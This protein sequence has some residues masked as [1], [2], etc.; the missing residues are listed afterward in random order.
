MVVVK[1]VAGR[2][3]RTIID[4]RALVCGCFQHAR[5]EGG[6]G[7]VLTRNGL[8]VSRLGGDDSLVSEFTQILGRVI[9]NLLG[10][11]AE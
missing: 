4:H 10:F 2:R 7:P 9:L 11:P 3:A 8:L 5:F 1:N 6:E